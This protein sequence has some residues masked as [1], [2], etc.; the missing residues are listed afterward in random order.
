MGVYGV[1]VPRGACD[2]GDAQ[3]AGSRQRHVTNVNDP[4]QAKQHP[5]SMT[6]YSA[7]RV[8]FNF[9]SGRVEVPLVNISLTLY[10]LEPT[11]ARD[12]AWPS[13]I[14]PG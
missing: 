8:S 2:C 4:Q 7:A 13:V 6:T 5:A 14:N 9:V 1:L 12:P 11:L 3:P 10:T